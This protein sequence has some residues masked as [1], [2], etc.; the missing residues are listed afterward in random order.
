MAAAEVVIVEQ[1]QHTDFAQQAQ[2]DTPAACWVPGDYNKRFVPH[3]ILQT[4]SQLPG[5]GPKRSF[6]K[7][8]DHFRRVF[9]TL[10]LQLVPLPNAKQQVSD[11]VILLQLLQT[12]RFLLRMQKDSEG[13]FSKR[14]WVCEFGLKPAQNR[15]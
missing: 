6:P 4:H 1:P 15:E 11:Y 8:Y 2:H 13:F 7:Q 9:L 12:G 5:A 10:L 3:P 14:F